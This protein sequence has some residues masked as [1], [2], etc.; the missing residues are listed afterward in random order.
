MSTSVNAHS[1]TPTRRILSNQL[2]EHG[3]YIMWYSEQL[4]TFN[5]ARSFIHDNIKYGAT[6]FRVPE[7]LVKATIYPMRVE[8]VD[9]KWYTQGAE[10]RTFTDGTWVVSYEAIPKEVDALKVQLTAEAMT[11]FDSTLSNSDRFVVRQPE[12]DE[13]MVNRAINPALKIWRADV[14]VVLEDRLV[15]IAAATTHQELVDLGSTPT[16]DPQPETLVLD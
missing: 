6:A 3:E 11:W 4:G 13:Y 12:M 2:T 1:N 10:S 14:F 8:P 7:I 9:T 15:A 5:R 16:V